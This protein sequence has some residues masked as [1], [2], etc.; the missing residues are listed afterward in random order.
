[1]PRKPKVDNLEN[2]IRT[3]RDQIKATQ[4][5][6]GRF[7]RMSVS[8]IRDLENGRKRIGPAFHR[9]QK[10][11][12]Y[13]YSI[14][15]KTWQL[16]LSPKRC[17]WDTTYRIQRQSSKPEQKRKDHE[18]L[19]YR[20][21]ALL[22]SASP[23]EY[24]ALFVT[25]CEFLESCLNEHPGPEAKKAFKRSAPKTRFVFRRAPS[26]YDDE[27]TSV[28][29]ELRLP[30]PGA[31]KNTVVVQMRTYEDIPSARTLLPKLDRPKRR[32]GQPID[33]EALE[34]CL[35]ALA[36]AQAESVLGEELENGRDLIVTEGDKPGKSGPRPRVTF[37]SAAGRLKPRAEAFKPDVSNSPAKKPQSSKR[38]KPAA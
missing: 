34:T 19:T 18:S 6:L 2:P 30:S 8:D 14:P 23:E 35:A 17:S 13:E 20:I 12:G 1:M 27:E 26:A 3:L 28:A 33:A 5:E 22:A 10:V 7:L 38:Q 25:L 9:I 32:A 36:S 16:P 21:A 29:E 4:D 37:R 15:K 31:Q 11:L 24:N